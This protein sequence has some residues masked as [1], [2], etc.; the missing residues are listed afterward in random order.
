M[1]L[2]GTML[3]YSNPFSLSVSH[4]FVKLLDWDPLDVLKSELAPLALLVEANKVC[5]SLVFLLKYVKNTFVLF[6][7]TVV[8]GFESLPLSNN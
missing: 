1:T 2:R 3:Q 4:F 5:P 6:T 7:F 8:S